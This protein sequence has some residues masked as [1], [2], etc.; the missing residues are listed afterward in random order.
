MEINKDPMGRAIA[1]YQSNGKVARLRVFSPMFDEDEIPVKTL[2][3]RYKEMP[4]IERRAL[5]MSRGRV[6]DVGAGA[7]CHSLA[8]QDKGIDVTAIDISPLSVATMRQR[9]VKN[10]VEQDFFTLKGQYDTI[11]MLMNGIGIVGRLE[12]MA[13]FFKQLD[14]LLAEGGQL[15]CDSS[16][17]CYLYEDEDGVIELPSEGYYGEQ[18]FRMQYKDVQGDSF[19]WIYID[20]DT[21]TQV[22]NA[23][24]YNVDIVAEGE[25]YD[26]LARIVKR[27]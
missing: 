26:Y 2:F 23:N 24:G 18:T 22:A 6:L 17:I 9:G 8:L 4:K 27:K 14:I 21:L 16:D 12:R 10:V 3:R 13:E 1:D 25:H 11:L 15:L 7:G 19:P 20:A 5:D